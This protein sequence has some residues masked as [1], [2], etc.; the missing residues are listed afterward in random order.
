MRCLITALINSFPCWQT[1]QKAWLHSNFNT[2]MDA[3]AEWAWEFPAQL[4]GVI[5]RKAPHHL[6]AIVYDTRSL[7]MS[8]FTSMLAMTRKVAIYWL[9][10]CYKTYFILWILRGHFWTVSSLLWGSFRICPVCGRVEWD[11]R[12]WVGSHNRIKQLIYSPLKVP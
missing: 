6:I 12:T 4:T 3:V 5:H 10:I 9:A 11:L 8:Q 1:G 7:N 2:V